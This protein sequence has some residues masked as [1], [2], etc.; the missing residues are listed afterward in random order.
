MMRWILKN[1]GISW[2]FHD[3]VMMMSRSGFLATVFFWRHT[4]AQA[5][6]MTPEI[7]MMAA[8][9]RIRKIDF[10]FDHNPMNSHVEVSWMGVPPVIIHFNGIFPHKPTIWGVPPWLPWRPWRPCLFLLLQS[11]EGGA[12]FRSWFRIPMNYTTPRKPR[13]IGVTKY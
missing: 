6:L 2:W 3:D 7:F 13:F 10:L 4:P 12:S 11:Q 9:S 1:Y 8:C 5:R